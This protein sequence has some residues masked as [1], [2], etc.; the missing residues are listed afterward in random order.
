MRFV[1]NLRGT[2]RQRV[3]SG[4]SSE[5]TEETTASMAVNM[6]GLKPVPLRCYFYIIL[7]TD[8]EAGIV[9]EDSCVV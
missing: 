8:K 4:H 5:G 1:D 9:V 2:G 6:A 3:V 7:I